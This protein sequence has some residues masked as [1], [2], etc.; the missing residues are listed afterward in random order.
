MSLDG[1]TAQLSLLAGFGVD[2]VTILTNVV[3]VYLRGRIS[4][5]LSP[6]PPLEALLGNVAP[7]R[8]VLEARALGVGL[9]LVLVIVIVPGKVVKVYD[10]VC[11][12]WR[13]GVSLDRHEL[14]HGG[15]G[16]SVV[17]GAVPEPL[18][19]QRGLEGHVE[20]GTGVRG[21][22]LQCDEDRSN[23]LGVRQDLVR[24]SLS[25]HM[26]VGQMFGYLD[27]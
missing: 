25:D 11:N 1:G 17:G 6:L 7:G 8:D 18:E 13:I 3:I 27:F 24:L 14:H 4:L 21:V 12:L 16:P 22:V 19:D 23:P 26:G 10:L 9:G 15:V 2:M 20:A 5:L